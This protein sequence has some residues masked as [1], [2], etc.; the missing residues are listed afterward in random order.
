MPVKL[1]S[2]N[3]VQFQTEIETSTLSQVF[4]DAIAIA[5][6]LGI[7]YLW[8]D[9][10]YIQ[11]D[12]D[13]LDWN[14][15]SQQM[16]KVYANALLNLSA[17]MASS[18]AES[19]LQ[20]RSL[21]PIAPSKVKIIH[22]SRENYYLVDVQIWRDEVDDAPLSRRGW[23]FQERFLARRILHFGPRQLA[24][25]CQEFEALEM[26]PQGLHRL[27]TFFSLSKTSRLS[28]AFLAGTNAGARGIQDDGRRI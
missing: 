4:Q 9:S 2:S 22:P 23:V 25:E 11:Q 3:T 26:F 21:G 10:L 14:V 24:W 7:Y 13:E 15:E 16:D 18:G 12:E 19:L 28:K 17:T 27:T 1:L 20:S 5:Q 8:I 6:H